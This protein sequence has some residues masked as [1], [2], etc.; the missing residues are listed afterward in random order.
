MKV[1]SVRFTHYMA[2]GGGVCHS[3]A[4]FTVIETSSYYGRWATS[5]NSE[6]FWGSA[7][8]TSLDAY[9]RCLH[10]VLEDPIISS[11]RP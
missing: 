8:L 3:A 10:F 2:G 9:T 4:S 6:G 1:A 5:S 11:P 7:E